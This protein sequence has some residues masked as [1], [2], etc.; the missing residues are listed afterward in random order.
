MAQTKKYLAKYILWAACLLLL[1]GQLPAQYDINQFYYRGRQALMDG[2]YAKAIDNFNILSRLDSTSHE[3]YFFRGIAKYNLGDFIGAEQDFIKTLTINPVYTG[4]YH[5]RAITRSRMGQ[6]E[7]ALSDLATALELRPSYTGLYYSRGVTYF[8]FQQFDQA[9]ADFN[10]YLAKESSDPSAYLNRGAAYLYVGDTTAALNDYNQAIT[11]NRFDAEG[12]IRR[13]R[14]LHLQGHTEEALQDLDV[15]LEVD[16]TNSFAYFNRALIRHERHEI[17]GALSDLNRVLKDDPGNALTLYNRALIYSQIGDFRKAL[18]DYDRVLHINPRNVLAYFNRASVFLELERYQDAEQDY[19][20]AI[21]L[22]PDFAKA[23]MNRSYVKNLMGDQK[24][25]QTDYK[26]AQKKVQEY[27]GRTDDTSMVAAL[28]DTSG[29]FSALL[30]LDANFAKQDFND[31]L[32]QYRDIDINLK[33]LYQLTYSTQEEQVNAL[34]EEQFNSEALLQLQARLPITTRL[35]AH[36][37]AEMS[38]AGNRPLLEALT[39]EAMSTNSA[40]LWFAKAI[41]ERDQ[42]QFNQ[43]LEDYNRAIELAPEEAIFYLNRGALHVDMID[44]LSSLEENVQ[45]LTLDDSGTT[46]AR[47]Q[48]RNIRSYDYNTAIL[49]V[50]K[51]SMLQPENPFIYYNLGNLFCYA[52]DLPE[53]IRQY[54]EAIKLYPHLAEAFYNR[55][56]ILIYLKDL[57]KGCIDMSKAGELG[58]ADAYSVIRKYCMEE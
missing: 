17:E 29:R 46:R 54:D 10:R 50:V 16:S 25:A 33:P 37:T 32:L 39:Q 57:E 9:I 49:D 5:Y 8:L 30:S 20:K 51:A 14:I 23:Y 35:K 58:I 48:D 4:G 45:I 40:Y 22:Y 18:D 19:S 6:Y 2:K 34:L 38:H 7:N 27:R 52:K 43:A 1:A 36:S 55:G 12:Y 41:L 31:E 44:F 42:K 26:A 21:D 3:A 24:G 13:S 28:A 47:V 11:L 53:A 15:A 56:L